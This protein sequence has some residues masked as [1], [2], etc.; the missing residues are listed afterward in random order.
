MQ[1]QTKRNHMID[2]LFPVA[3]FFVFS[4]S[5]LTVMILAAG[6]YRSTTEASSLNDNAR[7]ALSYLAEKVHQS[8]ENGSVS[9]GTFDGCDTLILEQTYDNENYYTYIYAY[10]NELKELF[11]K[12]GSNAGASNGKTIL[13]VEDFSMESINENLLKFQCVD[14]NG[15][16]ASVIVGLESTE[17]LL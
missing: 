10:K 4:L 14:N 13:E 8:D 9:L 2:F 11:I 12:E 3:L 1:L 6:I 17:K 7:T 5:A 16:L 15:R